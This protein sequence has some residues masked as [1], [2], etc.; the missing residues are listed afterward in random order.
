MLHAVEAGSGSRSA[1]W[2]GNIVSAVRVV[3]WRALVIWLAFLIDNIVNYNRI[4]DTAT[5]KDIR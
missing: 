3:R 1:D 2:G 4:I 5:P